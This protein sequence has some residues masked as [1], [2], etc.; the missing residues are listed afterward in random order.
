MRK[1]NQAVIERCIRAAQK[2]GLPVAGVELRDDGAIRVLTVDGLGAGDSL[3]P[4]NDEWD[5]VLG[6]S[7]P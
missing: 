1:P 2:T 6:E 3:P 7:A 4:A 5:D